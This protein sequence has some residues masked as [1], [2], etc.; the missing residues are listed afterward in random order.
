[1]CNVA[2]ALAVFDQLDPG[3]FARLLALLPC[4]GRGGGAAP[5][6]M[7]AAGW[8]QVF[9]CAL[10]LQARKNAAEL[11]EIT[12]KESSGSGHTGWHRGDCV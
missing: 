8:C 10:Y 6:R 11:Q 9:Q 1:V 7:A 12:A 5:D 4:E 2:W 3:R